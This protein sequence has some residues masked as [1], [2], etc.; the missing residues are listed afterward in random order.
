MDASASSFISDRSAE[1]T[2]MV[3]GRAH[4]MAADSQL[5]PPSSPDTARQKSNRT[6]PRLCFSKLLRR[7]K[8]LTKCPSSD[9]VAPIG[10]HYHLLA[11]DFALLPESP[12]ATECSSAGTISTDEPLPEL[13]RVSASYHD[14]R[15]FASHQ[16]VPLPPQP[17][18][19]L[20]PSPDTPELCQEDGTY[21]QFRNPRL[22]RDQSDYQS[23][24]DLHILSCYYD[25]SEAGSLDD[26][27]RELEGSSHE[28][29]NSFGDDA[30]DTIHSEDLQRTLKPSTAQQTLCSEEADWLANSTTPDERLRRFKARC[31][32]V[33]QYP[34]HGVQDENAPNSIVSLCPRWGVGTDGLSDSPL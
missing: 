21:F 4:C 25:E 14:L 26:T 34:L 33:I 30:S 20:L 24:E 23:Y 31:F 10:H 8:M 3:F 32:Q 12:A 17:T 16:C 27:V 11:K 7:P 18:T 15:S 28:A 2:A 6:G 19:P 9:A 1:A 29:N 5:T 13:R 22:P